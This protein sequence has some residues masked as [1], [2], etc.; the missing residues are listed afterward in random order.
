MELRDPPT[1]PHILLVED[2]TISQ[3]Y[4][5]AVLES[6][7]ARVDATA[8]QA[9]AL[10]RA[11][12]T[13]YDLWLI[14][15]SLP[16]GT[17]TE[18]LAQLLDRWPQPPPALAHTAEAGPGPRAEALRAGFGDLLVKPVSSAGLAAAVRTALA[19]GVAL[20]DWDNAAAAIA[21]NHDPA[22]VKALRRLFLDELPGAHAAVVDS[23]RK[24]DA[25]TLR[26]RL[27]RLQ[28]SCGLVGAPRLA[29]A[30]ESLRRTPESH[31]ALE[32]FDHAARDLIR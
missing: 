4:F 28:A 10:A 24:G 22:N 14:D 21:L 30:V 32:R 29:D 7:P 23:A 25:A 26:A 16:D 31:A 13:R 17:G 27:H 9:C 5:R 15:L 20:P 2:D 19:A 6:L 1:L 11:R 8:T 12:A 3:A 18:L